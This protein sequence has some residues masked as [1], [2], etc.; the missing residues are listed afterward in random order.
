MLRGIPHPD[1]E[2]G[3]QTERF[4][5]DDCQGEA[6][7]AFQRVELRRFARNDVPGAENRGER[8]RI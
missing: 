6:F 5:R 2:V 8:R 1:K 4:G 7:G 3:A